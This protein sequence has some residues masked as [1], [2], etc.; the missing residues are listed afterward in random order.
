MAPRRNDKHQPAVE[1]TNSLLKPD[2]EA[3]AYGFDDPGGHHG[4]Q[5][6]K[7][8]R[9]LNNSLKKSFMAAKERLSALS[10]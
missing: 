9:Y 8:T 10:L 3:S 6:R 5:G 1:M 7:E 4:G 2:P